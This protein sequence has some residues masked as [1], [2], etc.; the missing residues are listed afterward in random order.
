MIKRMGTLFLFITLTIQAFCPEYRTLY[1]AESTGINPYERIFKAICETESSND[2]KAWNQKENA[3]GIC[4]IRPIRL[5]DFNKQSGKHYK[6]SEMYS[7][8]KSKEVFMFFAHQHYCTDYENI[9]LDWNCRSQK[10]WNKVK[11]ELKKIRI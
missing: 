8:E 7:V 3:V 11:N 6:L 4:Q 9:A 5:M 1:I 2:S 10:Y